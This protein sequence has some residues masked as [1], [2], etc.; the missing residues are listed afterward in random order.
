MIDLVGPYCISIH[1]DC[2]SAFNLSS[3]CFLLEEGH[4]STP[5][6]EIQHMQPPQRMSRL[7]R[8]GFIQISEGVESS[9]MSLI[10]PEF[11]FAFFRYWIIRIHMLHVGQTG[12]QESE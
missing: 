11:T 12:K 3:K 8:L 5:A 6:E 7:I 4:P 2:M 9:R 1:V 10:V